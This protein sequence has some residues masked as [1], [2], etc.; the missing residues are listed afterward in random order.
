MNQKSLVESLGADY[1]SGFFQDAF[2]QIDNKLHKVSTADD[3]L[4][5]THSFSLSSKNPRWQT[6]NVPQEMLRS[7][8]DFAYPKL[9]YRQIISPHIGNIVFN[10]ESIRSSHRGL[11]E[12]G[13]RVETLINYN[14]INVTADEWSSKTSS[15]RAKEL[16][17]PTFTSFAD[18][19]KQLLAGEI[20]G[21]AVSEDIAVVVSCGADV[22]R[23]YEILFRD[24]PVGSINQ[25]GTLFLNNK[26]MQRASLRKKFDK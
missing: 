11:R 17:A 26:I 15:Q 14:L 24:K 2:F 21:F 13:L 16:F 10:I 22:G 23:H 3:R 6:D 12:T 5:Y 18:G 20:F 1:I 4:I 19:I 9:G 25:D 8:S 7:F